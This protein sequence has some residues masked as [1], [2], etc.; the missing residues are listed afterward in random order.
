M[1][2][3][4]GVDGR[5]SVDRSVDLS[6]DLSADMERTTYLISEPAVFIDW[7][8]SGASVYRLPEQG[9]TLVEIGSDEVAA[10]IELGSSTHTLFSHN[11]ITGPIW[12]FDETIS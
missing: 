9:G 12:R 8:L 4:K 3:D 6:V 1:I 5:L 7:L 10:C 11:K 2:V